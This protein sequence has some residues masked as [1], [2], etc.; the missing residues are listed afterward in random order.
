MIIDRALVK[1]G[2]YEPEESEEQWVINEPTELSWGL[3][4]MSLK[5]SSEFRIM[6]LS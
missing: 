2:S 5:G 1:E 4:S 6:N 3:V